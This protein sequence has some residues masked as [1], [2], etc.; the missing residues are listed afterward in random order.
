MPSFL[1]TARSSKNSSARSGPKSADA[2]AAEVRGRALGLANPTGG[3]DSG[4][5]AAG[6]TKHNLAAPACGHKRPSASHLRY[7]NSRVAAAALG[8]RL[9][10]GSSNSHSQPGGL[11]CGLAGGCIEPQDIAAG[12]AIG[13][14]PRGGR[15]EGRLQVEQVEVQQQSLRMLEDALCSCLP[16]DHSNR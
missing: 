13:G 4:W 5:E 11:A 16:E 14:Q 2:C 1:T 7:R 10:E 9:A 6:W 8:D 15:R 3:P 12:T